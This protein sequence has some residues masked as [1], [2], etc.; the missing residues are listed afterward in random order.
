ML[1]AGISVIEV[2]LNSPQPLESIRR[3]A[4][5][6]GNEALIGAGTVLSR[7]DVEAVA[8][9]G[10]RLIVSPN[11]SVDVIQASKACSLTSYPG[12]MT[13]T[14]CFQALQHGADGLKFF[15]SFLLGPDG[16]TALSAVLPVGTQTFAVGGVGPE[17]FWAWLQAGVT[18]FGIGS[19]LYKAGFSPDD[20]SRRARDI[21]AA[22]DESL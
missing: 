11:C 19:A 8:E 3:L 16:L 22:F 21:V 7:E 6:F 10:A 15:P 14:E 12:V 1:D 4:H 18:G 5:Q 2:P 20:V 13:A 17:N 9:A